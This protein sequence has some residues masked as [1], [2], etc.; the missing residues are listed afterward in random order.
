MIRGLKYLWALPAT[1]LGAMFVPLAWCSG[2]KVEVIEGALEVYGGVPALWLRL[3]R[4]SAM[5]IGH[6]ILGRDKAAL[7]LTRAHEHVHIKQYEAWGCFLYSRLFSFFLS[8]LAMLKASLLRQLLRARSVRE[9]RRATQ[10]RAE[11]TVRQNQATR[12]VKPLERTKII[13]IFYRH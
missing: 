3:C 2:G 11:L 1:L 5:T 12:Q 10:A 9:N 4:A 8:R 7:Q 13:A 6:V